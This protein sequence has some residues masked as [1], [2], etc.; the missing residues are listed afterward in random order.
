VCSLKNDPAPTRRER[1]SGFLLK[2]LPLI[3]FTV[4]LALLFFLN[5]LDPY[6]KVSAQT[7]F[8][9]MWKGRTFQLFFLW[10]IA[11]EFILSWE[12]I[13]TKIDLHNKARFLG[14]V[15][16]LL[17]P[18]LYMVLE[19][20]FGLNNAIV[21]WSIQNG[22]TWAGTMPIA[23]EYLLFSV[24]FCLAVFASFGRKGLTGSALP[25]LFVALVGVI[26]VIDNV[27]PYGEF[28][29][30]Q[31]LVPTTASLAAGMLGL[32]GYST[33]SGIDT[34]TGMP[35]LDVSGALG[36]AKFAIAWPCA[37]I[38]SLLIFTAVALLFLKRLNISWRAKIGYFVVGAVVTYF[39]N[40]LRIAAIFTIGMQFGVDSDQVYMFHF[41][42]GPLY[43]MAWIVT[44]PII[45]LAST[46]VW[47]RI[48]KPQPKPLNPV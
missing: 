25:T 8:E 24:L 5:P 42:Y 30:F 46:S 9:L 7:S 40:A 39:I 22:V 27:F 3:A 44:Y 45:I 19:Y 37:G 18:T 32:M 4:P 35:T 21:N 2:I 13:K 10:L 23:L 31:L 17:L 12:T 34:L 48:R 36:S 38:E 16:T 11:L 43:A 33:V 47:R 41:Y 28:T 1:Y 14:F 29:P 20:Y 6:L 15:V 26:Y